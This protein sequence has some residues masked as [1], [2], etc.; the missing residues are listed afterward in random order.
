MGVVFLILSALSS[1]MHLGTPRCAKA[2]LSNIKSHDKDLFNVVIEK[3]RSR[4][5]S[6]YALGRLA[7][8]VV[9]HVV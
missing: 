4:Q 2:A 6:N 7:E 9:L 8:M 1:P 3:L 5:G